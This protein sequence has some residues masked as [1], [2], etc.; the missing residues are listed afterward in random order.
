MGLLINY[1]NNLIY[2][3]ERENIAKEREKIEREKRLEQEAT[4]LSP[5]K[6]DPLMFAYFEITKA[7][8]MA[9]ETAALQA[10]E[11]EANSNAQ[12]ELIAREG[13]LHFQTLDLMIK[14][15]IDDAGGKT[16]IYNW[17]SLKAQL[18]GYGH[19]SVTKIHHEA[20]IIARKAIE[21]LERGQITNTILEQ[22]STNNEEIQ[23]MRNML[24]AQ[25]NM[26]SNSW[27][28]GMSMITVSTNNSQNSVQEG[29]S[30]MRMLL[31]LTNQIT[32][33]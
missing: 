30:L 7:V 27:Q 16:K 18:L 33:A 15:V 28:M 4:S 23:G 22:I 2:A 8:N 31:N 10:K 26:W 11:L 25:L 24:E 1:Y 12:N 5:Q 17:A 9:H 14:Q 21:S 19:W 3:E 29:G 32:K 6:L 13:Q 20:D